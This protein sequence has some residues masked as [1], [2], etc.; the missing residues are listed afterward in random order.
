MALRFLN[1]NV[2]IEWCFSCNTGKPRYSWE[3]PNLFHFSHQNF[4]YG[5][6]TTVGMWFILNFQSL[7]LLKLLFWVR[8]SIKPLNI[9]NEIFTM[10]YCSLE[11]VRGRCLEKHAFTSKRLQ[12]CAMY[13]S[14]NSPNIYNLLAIATKQFETYGFTWI[15]SYHNSSLPDIDIN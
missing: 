7:L 10:R 13:W 5:P 6:K 9:S 15:E 2:H 8:R 1:L 4:H 12:S 14:K 11:I 3:Q